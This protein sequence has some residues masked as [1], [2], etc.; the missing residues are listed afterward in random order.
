MKLFASRVAQ[1]AFLLT[2]AY[3]AVASVVPT[4][5]L[6]TALSGAF[7][8]IAG[9]VLFVYGPLIAASITGKFHRVAML[10]LG[11][12]C[13][14]LSFVMLRVWSIYTRAYGSPP[15]LVNH[16]V[17]GYIVF[18]ALMGGILHVTAPGYPVEPV[19]H[20]FGGRYRWLIVG[21]IIGGAVLSFGVSAIIRG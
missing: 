6:I 14:F 12:G 10:A 11:M 13:I 4:K 8:G 21:A 5:A 9:V 16:P 15:E 7:L 1:W 18:V 20:H 3:C 2:L 19:K 17:V